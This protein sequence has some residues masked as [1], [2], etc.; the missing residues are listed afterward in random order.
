MVIRD[1]HAEGVPILPDKANTKLVVDADAVLPAA[2]ALQGFQPMAWRNSHEVQRGGG[3]ELGQLAP[4]H[5]LDVD[6]AAYTLAMGE[7]RRV[8]VGEALILTLL[9]IGKR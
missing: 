7:G 6:P 9:H 3:M 8:L 4:G 2:I 5:A 1:F